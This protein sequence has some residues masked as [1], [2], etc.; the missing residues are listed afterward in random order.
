MNRLL[1]V[2]LAACPL[3]ACT[4][5]DPADASRPAPVAEQDYI[6]GSRLPARH[7]NSTGTKV[8]EMNPIDRDEL[9]R[10][11]STTVNQ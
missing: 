1:L 4:L 8:Y 5:L 10:P 9:T 3:G 11:K 6:T 7:H 2:L